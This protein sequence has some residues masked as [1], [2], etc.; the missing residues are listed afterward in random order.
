MEVWR[1]L[2]GIVENGENYALSTCGNVV[3]ITTGLALKPSQKR[4][5]YCQVVLQRNKKRRYYVVH[6]LVAIAFLEN[7]DNKA[8]VNHI[9]GVKTNNHVS[10]LEWVTPS[11]NNIHAIKTG[12]VNIEKQTEILVKFNSQEVIQYDLNGHVINRFS[13]CAEASRNTGMLADTIQKQCRANAKPRFRN[14]YFR[15]ADEKQ[16][17]RKA[18]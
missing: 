6:R 2:N 10:N 17:E 9:D 3:N 1:N 11:E 14:F 16:K 12:L 15:F 18:N 5:G 4:S 8:M 7:P 13:S